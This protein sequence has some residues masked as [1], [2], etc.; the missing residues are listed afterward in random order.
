[1]ALAL[2]VLLAV[3]VALLAYGDTR[4]LLLVRPLYRYFQRSLP[5]MSATEREAIAAGDTW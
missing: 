2:L 5:P 3:A 1:M 4:R